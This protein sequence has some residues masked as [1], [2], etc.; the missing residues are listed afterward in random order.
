MVSEKRCG[1][2]ERE[3]TFLSYFGI[4]IES[5]EEECGGKRGK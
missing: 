1:E 2:L 3:C 5:D 4:F